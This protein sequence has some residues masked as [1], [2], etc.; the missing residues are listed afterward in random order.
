MRRNTALD[1]GLPRGMSSTGPVAMTWRAASSLPLE[2]T[3]RLAP[4]ASVTQTASSPSSASTAA[5]LPGISTPRGRRAAERGVR[6]PDAS[7]SITKPLPSGAA[8]S[9][10]TCA[11]ALRATPPEEV[12][13]NAAADTVAVPS[14]LRSTAASSSAA[15][16]DAMLPGI[17]TRR[18]RAPSRIDR[19]DEPSSP[20]CSTTCVCPVGSSGLGASRTAPRPRPS[21]Q[22]ARRRASSV[23]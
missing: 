11:I 9:D 2:V 22:A 23:R 3:H 20:S 7:T 15:S 17:T 18:A 14:A 4:C 1:R 5:R 16:A 12:A 6:L 21:A 19:G 8:R 13:K 10:T